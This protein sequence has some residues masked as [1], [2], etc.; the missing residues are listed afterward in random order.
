MTSVAIMF[1][2]IIQYCLFFALCLIRLRSITPLTALRPAKV[3]LGTRVKPYM[4]QAQAA[5][6]TST[7]EH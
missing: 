1:I 2:P 6:A 3:M 7:F 4:L 5:R